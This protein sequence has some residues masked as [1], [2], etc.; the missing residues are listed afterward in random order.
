MLFLLNRGKLSNNITASGRNLSLILG[1][2]DC[3]NCFDKSCPLG[4]LDTRLVFR[5]FVALSRLTLLQFEGNKKYWPDVFL[6]FPTYLTETLNV[7]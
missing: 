3:I 4:I 2:F 7:D 5:S 6:V 1:F